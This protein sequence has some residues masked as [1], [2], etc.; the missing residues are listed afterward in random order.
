V[1]KQGERV[2]LPQIV[3]ETDYQKRRFDDAGRRR[4]LRS[5]EILRKKKLRA[6]L[7]PE[8]HV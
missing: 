6:T 4:E 2:K 5:P 8:W 1:D 3:P 7:T